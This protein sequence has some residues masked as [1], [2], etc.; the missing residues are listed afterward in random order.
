MNHEFVVYFSK[1]DYNKPS[2]KLLIEY[3]LLLNSLFPFVT[4]A[5]VNA[6]Q[7]LSTCRLLCIAFATMNLAPTPFHSTETKSNREK[8]GLCGN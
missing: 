3:P 8:M 4:Y 2:R 6:I 5:N 1:L 7:T